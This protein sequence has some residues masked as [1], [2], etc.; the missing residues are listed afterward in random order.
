MKAVIY[1]RVSSREQ[2]ETGYSLDSQ[3]KLA[4]EYAKNKEFELVKIF[5]N[6]ESASGKQVRKT[7]YEML[8]FA[9]K[10]KV[11]V[12]LCE[13]IDRLTR[14]PKDASII[15][16]WIQEDDS[17]QIHFVKENFILSKN[18]RAH[19]N[20]V[21]DMKVAI[22]RFY[23][24]NL[25]EEVRKGQKEKISQGWLPTKPPLG[26]KTVGDKGKKI[27]VI[28]DDVAPFITKMFEKY[29]SGLYSIKKLSDEM[30][31]EGFRS[32]NNS[33]VVKS[34][35]HDLLTDPFYYGKLRWKGKVYDGQHQ[36][37]ISKDLFDRVQKLSS[38]RTTP[39]YSTHSYL[40][41]GLIR[42]AECG[43]TV[44]WE[45]QK[46]TVY[47]HCNRYRNC[48]KKTFY[49]EAELESQVSEIFETLQIKNERLA[50]WI[51]QALQESHKS[52]V[53]YR[54]NALKSLQNQLQRVRQRID[55]I[56]EDRLD[57]R[58]DTALYDSK[59]AQFRD[60]RDSLEAEIKRYNETGD[61]QKDLCINIFDL[62][63]KARKLYQ[64]ATLEEKR[65][66][67]SLVFESMLIE[68]GVIKFTYT[69][70][71]EVL[72]SAVLET[73]RSKA[74]NSI[75]SPITIFELLENGSTEGQKSP[76]NPDLQPLLR[77]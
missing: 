59:S 38:S 16:E 56:Y 54:L 26:Y 3:I 67:I 63:Q 8:A 52:E 6:S 75:K 30:Y 42:C 29:S 11:G 20:L 44:T 22:A 23:T 47:G 31:E 18:T 73:N 25:S 37:L 61:K 13:K 49:K 19:E 53:E 77:G 1:A 24:N 57:N 69:K 64:K 74:V 5:K 40:F 51:K 76:L 43:G 12:I 4:E 2:E 72:A 58:I 17:R 68:N 36:A 66:L 71:F 35:T 9:T 33:K 7:F 27:H 62:S 50:G 39:T 65:K 28:N 14:N 48:S 46:G 70:P 10:N 55:R 41:K 21:W 45:I 32:R 34:R 15:D 60:E